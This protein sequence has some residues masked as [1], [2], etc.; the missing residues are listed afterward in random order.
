MSLEI[1][2]KN[3]FDQSKNNFDINRQHFTQA[4]H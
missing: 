4:Y 3:E 2:L 1:V